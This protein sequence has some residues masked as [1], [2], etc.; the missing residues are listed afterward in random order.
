MANMTLQGHSYMPYVRIW[1]DWAVTDFD[2][3]S[4]LR[5]SCP[6]TGPTD[7]GA[8]NTRNELQYLSASGFLATLT[9]PFPPLQ[10]VLRLSGTQ[11]S[12]LLCPIV[13]QCNDEVFHLVSHFRTGVVRTA[14]VENG[15]LSLQ[16]TVMPARTVTNSMPS[17][18][19][20]V[21]TVPTSS[22]LG[23]MS[24]HG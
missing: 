22:C 9:T 10:L 7:K 19:F 18:A 16:V 3:F 13:I 1:S 4:I 24:V 23:S 2:T 11:I 20:V 12:R 6:A 17:C 21:R 8:R 5:A 15:F 14:Q